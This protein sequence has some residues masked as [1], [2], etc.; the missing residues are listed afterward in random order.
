MMPAMSTRPPMPPAQVERE[1]AV[2]ERRADAARLGRGRVERIDPHMFVVRPAAADGPHID[3][4][5]TALVHGNEVGGMLVLNALCTLLES[6]VVAPPISIGMAL[7]NPDAARH[8][9]RQ[10][11]RDMN[12]TFGR[13]ETTT[14]E[15]RRARVVESAMRRARYCVDLHQT[16]EPSYTPFLV[17]RYDP[18]KLRFAQGIFPGVPIVTHWGG[19]PFSATPGGGVMV[20]EFVH[21]HGGVAVGV[22]LG[23]K[24]DDPVQIAAGLGLCLRAIALVA[25]AAGDRNALPPPSETANPLYTWRDIVPYPET[26]VRLHPGLVNFQAI[27]AGQELGRLPGGPLRASACGYLMVPKY[28]HS[29]REPKPAELYRL[30]RRTHLGELGQG[31]CLRPP[32]PTT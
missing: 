30:L 7:C 15:D 27:E 23:Q 8:G 29:E 22:E 6:T 12:R 28:V 21:C 2:F 16:I 13:T 32:K 18:H 26:Q 24:G 4:L 14:I 20:D 19:Q 5:L 17:F 1:L 31:E 10:L 9:V 11:E 25:A 3:L